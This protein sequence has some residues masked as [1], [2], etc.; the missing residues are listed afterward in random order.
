MSLSWSFVS[1]ANCSPDQ[2]QS[3]N[4]NS[5]HF[6]LYHATPALIVF[7][8]QHVYSLGKCY[9]INRLTI[10]MNFSYGFNSGSM[11]LVTGCLDVPSISVHSLFCSG[12]HS[13]HSY[14]SPLYFT[15]S[16]SVSQLDSHFS[17]CFLPDLLVSLSL[18]SGVDLTCCITRTF[19]LSSA[20]YYWLIKVWDRKKNN[21]TGEPEIMWC[22]NGHW[23]MRC[24]VGS[25]CLKSSLVEILVTLWR[26]LT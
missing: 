8:Y 15:S 21:N 4:S 20:P 25:V 6:G 22:M 1:L 13:S 23:A 14:F 5:G 26:T 11:W 19:L 18:F 12:F 24:P 10:T 9:V 17:H 16:P 7:L 3:G 2:L